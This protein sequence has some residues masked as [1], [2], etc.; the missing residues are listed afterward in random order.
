[1]HPLE[2]LINLRCVYFRFCDTTRV[3]PSSLLLPATHQSDI[4]LSTFRHPVR[5]VRGQRIQTS[6][7]KFWESKEQWPPGLHQLSQ[8]AATSHATPRR[9]RRWTFRRATA[10]PKSLACV[11]PA[12]GPYAEKVVRPP[13]DHPPQSHLLRGYDWILRVRSM[14]EPAGRRGQ[15][16][17]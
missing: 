14:S 3:Q 11:F 16:V 8:E 7:P 17:R 4:V 5:E 6:R 12:P 15:R 10:P 1:M 13:Q 9:T 2:F